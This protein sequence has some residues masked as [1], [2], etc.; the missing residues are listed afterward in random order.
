MNG[1]GKIAVIGGGGWR[2]PLL[3]YGLSQVQETLGLREVALFDPDR[4][5]LSLISGL[6]EEILRQARSDIRIATP[7]QLEDAIAGADFIILSIRVGGMDSRARDERLAIEHGLVGQETIPPAGMAMALRTIPVILRQ[8]ELIEEVNPTAW[9]INFTNPVGIITQA[10]TTRTS[11]RVI[12]VCDTPMEL[13]HRIAQVLD[14]HAGD[15]QCDYFGLNHLGWVSDVRRGGESVMAGLLRDDRR[16]ENL[17]PTK[18]FPAE[19]IRR[20]GLIPSEYLYFFYAQ[21][22]AYTMQVKAGTSRAIELVELNDEL[23]AALRAA[24]VHEEKEKAVELYRRYLRRRSASYLKLEAEGQS[25]FAGSEDEWEDPFE[26]V[27]GY[28][29]IAVEVMTALAGSESKRLVVD[30]NN[31]GS[32]ADLEP[33]DVVEVPCLID[34]NGARPVVVGRLPE[35]VRGLVQSVKAYER[36]VIRAA[37]ERN[38]DL[39]R[40]AL[41]VHPLV[42]QWGLADRIVSRMLEDDSLHLG[43]LKSETDDQTVCVRGVP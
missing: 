14:L 31:C 32:I 30:V 13:F 28:H 8:A 11:L 18:L 23:A 36:L 15:I 20:L 42:G 16:L 5:R 39:A 10:I 19:F 21:R 12:G 29:R 27:T 38:E 41:T 4:H 26:A 9:I 43:Y 33:T 3:L 17:Y 37:V 7:F 40:L 34:K 24:F 2:I 25:A 6:G 35:N 1:N 22:G